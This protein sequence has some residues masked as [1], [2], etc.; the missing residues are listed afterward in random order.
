MFRLRRLLAEY[1]RAEK[2]NPK[3][4]FPARSYR[5]TFTFCENAAGTPEVSL[6]DIVLPEGETPTQDHGG[7]EEKTA[8]WYTN[9]AWVLVS[10][11]LIVVATTLTLWTRGVSAPNASSIHHLAPTVAVEISQGDPNEE[12]LTVL[13]EAIMRVQHLRIPV[14]LKE[15]S[16][17]EYRLV[18]SSFIDLSGQLMFHASLYRS[19]GTALLARS[20]EVSDINDTRRISND[21]IGVYDQF[22]GTKGAVANDVRYSNV[23][24]ARRREV[25]GCYLDAV[26]MTAGRPYGGQSAEYLFNCI[27]PDIVEIPEEKAILHIQRA[28][29]INRAAIGAIDLGKDYTLE[30]ARL[31]L[32]KAEKIYPIP[33]TLIAE[34]IQIEWQD[35]N[36]TNES[37]LML[38]N[39]AEEKYPTY[40]QQYYIATSHA[41]YL[42]DFEK[43]DIYADNLLAETEME[44]EA[45]GRVINFIP[46]PKLLVAKNYDKAL[47]HLKETGSVNSIIYAILYLDIGCAKNDSDMIAYGA[48]LFRRNSERKGMTLRETVKK[49]RYAPQLEAA[50]MEGLSTPQCQQ[51]LD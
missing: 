7:E 2:P 36:R 41:Y 3:I 11:F 50:L 39:K 33:A 48:T 26:E 49:R 20:F 32:E 30:D 16:P 40:Y 45:P 38:V 9:R 8:P 13:R 28:G 10:L 46:I 5:P 35:P 47:H 14:S 22:L 21:A 31:E 1:N 24:N 25:F 19:D 4:A 18:L 42:G 34:M 44:G 12:G 51:Y 29:L 23:Y 43:A 17:A 27:N 6:P 37:L 15:Q